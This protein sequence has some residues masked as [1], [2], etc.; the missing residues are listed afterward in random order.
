MG[1]ALR[2]GMAS[3]SPP[4][5]PVSFCKTLLKGESMHLKGKTRWGASVPL[6]WRAE[7]ESENEKPLVSAYCHN[8]LLWGGLDTLGT[9]AA[10]AGAPTTIWKKDD[11]NQFVVRLNHQR[12][13][14]LAFR[15]VFPLE[16][17]WKKER[18]KYGLKAD[19]FFFSFFPPCK[20]KH[21]ETMWRGSRR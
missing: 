15:I 1:T 20:M 17:R 21:S 19:F 10:P 7:R 6:L 2:T 13:P 14:R 11:K 16:S 9:G 5:L 3:P 18:K 12:L 4:S 8:G